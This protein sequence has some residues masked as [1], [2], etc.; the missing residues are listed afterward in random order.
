MMHRKPVE[1]S[2]VRRQ[3]HGREEHERWKKRA[4]CDDDDENRMS[5]T[6]LKR[7]EQCD[8][9]S[10]GSSRGKACTTERAKR[11]SEFG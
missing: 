10:D 6:E 3:K 9:E 11:K 2:S 1:A 4:F 8:E 5:E 7:L